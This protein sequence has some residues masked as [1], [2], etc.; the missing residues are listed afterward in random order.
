MSCWSVTTGLPEPGARPGLLPVTGLLTADPALREEVPR[1][2]APVATVL[3]LDPA[4]FLPCQVPVHAVLLDSSLF[5]SS[6]SLPRRPGR[7]CLPVL[8]LAR[9][10]L[11]DRVQ[12]FL[13]AVEDFVVW[14]ASE[15]ELRLRLKRLLAQG[16][17]EAERVTCGAVVVDG[18]RR[19][20]ALAGRSL[21]LTPREFGLLRELA[22]RCDRPV[23]RQE[24]LAAVWGW[25]EELASNVVDVVVASLRRKLR[26]QAGLIRTVRGLGYR[27]LASPQGGPL[28]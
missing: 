25:D 7:P 18:S 14:P 9:R 4:G 1:L 5:P 11:M 19:E 28:S 8:L 10:E 12:E 22:R 27:L 23:D 24:L 17:P 6:G 2:L 16:D 21:H 20:A 13:D 26:D 3:H 15:L